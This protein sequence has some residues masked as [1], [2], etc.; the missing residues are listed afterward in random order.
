MHALVVHYISNQSNVTYN[1]VEPGKP[2]VPGSLASNTVNTEVLSDEITKVFGTDKTN[3]GKGEKVHNTVTITNNSTTA[4]GSASIVSPIPDGA[5]FVEGSVKV[6]GVAAAGSN[7]VTGVAI[8]ELKPGETVTVEYDVQITNPS[9]DNLKLGAELKYNVNDPKIGEVTFT[10]PTNSVAID[11]YVAKLSVVKS[12]DKTF[13][14]K[15]DTLT[16]LITFGNDGN[17]DINDIYFTDAIPAGTTFVEKSVVVNDQ[18]FA[19]Y[20]PD[21]GYSIANLPPAAYVTTLFQVT[22]D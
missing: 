10:E 18:S 17:V 11:V 20:R 19:A 12:V 22:V 2:G 15:G 6:N 9:A 21:I 8:P 3:A 16:Y 5:S 1:A 4:L 13:A 7:P 14:V